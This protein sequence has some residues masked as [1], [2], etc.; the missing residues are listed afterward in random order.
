MELAVKDFDKV[1]KEHEKNPENHPLYPEEW[2][3]FWNRRY[4]ELQSGLRDILNLQLFKV[5]F[6]REN[7][8][9]I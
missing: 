5:F 1:R 7:S 8:R 9:K 3:L 2:K 4:K 6:S